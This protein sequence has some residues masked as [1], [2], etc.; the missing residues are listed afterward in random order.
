MA[1]TKQ[2]VTLDKAAEILGISQDGIRKRI[3]R[4]TIEAV[5]DPAGRLK[6]IIEN[7]PRTTIKDTVQDRSATVID[8]LQQQIDFLKQELERRDTIIMSLTQR[9]PALEPPRPT[10]KRSFF[11]R[12]RRKPAESS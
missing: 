10:A 3:H 1:G 2:T 5:K 6:V 7:K 9:F 11:D 4:G 8:I 12:F